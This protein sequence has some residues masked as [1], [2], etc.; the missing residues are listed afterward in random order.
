MTQSYR[1]LDDVT[2]QVRTDGLPRVVRAVDQDGADSRHVVY[3]EGEKALSMLAADWL[4]SRGDLPTSPTEEEIQAA[5]DA[6]LA[7]RMRAHA[8]AIALRQRV[9][10]MAADAVGQ[11]VDALT[12]PQVRSLLV[13]LLWKAGALDTAGAPRPPDDWLD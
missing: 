10:D 6:Q 11:Q 2:D 7:E 4:D 12:A 9:M 1:L 5:I 3:R 13:L 8:D